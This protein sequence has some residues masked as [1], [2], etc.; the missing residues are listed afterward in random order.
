MRG[1]TPETETALATKGD[2]LLV[3]AMWADKLSVT[4]LGLTTAEHLL[5]GLTRSL[6]LWIEA[7]KLVKPVTKD[8][9]EG[10]KRGT[11][12]VNHVEGLAD[13]TDY[14]LESTT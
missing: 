7:K 6:I 14:L 3:V 1:P 10:L 9:F 5:D 2:D 8:Q 4:L 11:S 12:L 13:F